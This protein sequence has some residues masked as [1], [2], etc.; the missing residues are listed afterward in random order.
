[1]EMTIHRLRSIEDGN[2]NAGNA[3]AK[4]R[5]YAWLSTPH[6]R[7]MVNPC[8]QEK[9]KKVVPSKIPSP[10]NYAQILR[11]HNRP[12]NRMMRGKLETSTQDPSY[13]T[14]RL[15]ITKSKSN[16]QL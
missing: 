3:V 1:M 5:V 14:Q 8:C 10:G 15:M 11:T 16:S 4:G 7:D 6:T 2:R 9:K 12:E 13:A